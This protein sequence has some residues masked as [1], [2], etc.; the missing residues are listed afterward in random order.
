MALTLLMPFKMRGQIQDIERKMFDNNV[1]ELESKADKGDVSAMTRLGRLYSEMSY[2]G[3]P[4][5]KIRIDYRKAFYWYQQ[6]ALNGDVP[7]MVRVA[8]MYYFEG[9]VRKD[10]TKSL[11][12]YQ[13]AAKRG[14]VEALDTL[15]NLYKEGKEVKKDDAKAFDYFQKAAIQGD[16]TAEFYVGNMYG[17]CEYWDGHRVVP[18]DDKKAFE[19]YH[20]D[21]L[22]GHGFAQAALGLMYLHGEG[23]PKDDVMACVWMI[24]ANID[25]GGRD[26]NYYKLGAEIQSSVNQEEILKAEKLEKEMFP[27]PP[28]TPPRNIPGLDGTY[29]N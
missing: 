28:P 8:R 3:D 19:W 13:K 16:F 5:S 25:G 2:P 23:V 12:W 18:R 17:E 15:G 24:R 21:A 7:S 20:K 26:D 10:M 11:E 29:G 1:K 27:P 14:N 22:Q 9:G 4:F 6:A